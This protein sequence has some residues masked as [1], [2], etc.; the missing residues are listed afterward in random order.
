MEIHTV[1]ARAAL[2]DLGLK[3]H[4][5]DYLINR[6]KYVPEWDENDIIYIASVSVVVPYCQWL[7]AYYYSQP[8]STL[9]LNNIGLCL[10]L[11]G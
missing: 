5:K 2:G 8:S 10:Y 9:G 4:P 6:N 3:S 7:L 11:D 1:A